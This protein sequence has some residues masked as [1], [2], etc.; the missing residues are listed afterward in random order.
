[1]SIPNMG[2]LG[3]VVAS[4]CDAMV[5]AVNSLPPALLLPDDQ[6][7]A[8]NLSC[9]AEYVSAL[10]GKGGI[11]T[12]E[13]TQA[14]GAKIQIREIEG[15]TVEQAVTISGNVLSVTTAYLRVAGRIARA[16]ESRMN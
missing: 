11:G 9:P 8:I 5:N 13:I 1:M 4:D 15:N 14:T 10:I 12:K 6:S 16:A 7:A 3:D 2:M